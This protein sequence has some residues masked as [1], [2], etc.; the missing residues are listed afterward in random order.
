MKKIIPCVLVSRTLLVSECSSDTEPA[1]T[2]SAATKAASE[3][4]V[5]PSEKPSP[6]TKV[7]GVADSSPDTMEIDKKE[8]AAVV[9]GVITY[10]SEDDELAIT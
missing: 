10:G 2:P 3:A 7:A 4:S 8:I 6:Q 9:T 5:T 1:K